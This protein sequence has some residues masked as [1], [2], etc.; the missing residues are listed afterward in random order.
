MH[1]SWFPAA[2]LIPPVA[3][4]SYSPARTRIGPG[5]V[6]SRRALGSTSSQAAAPRKAKAVAVENDACHPK[7]AAISGVSEAVTAA[8]IWHPMFMAPETT[9]A[10]VPAKSDV[11]DQKQLC[12]R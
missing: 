3:S 1:E 9:P 7:R 12:A 5:R 11:T 2:F 10:K 6:C 4:A 8:P